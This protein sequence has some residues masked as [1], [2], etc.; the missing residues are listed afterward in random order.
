MKLKVEFLCKKR[1]KDL[2]FDCQEGHLYS[3]IYYTDRDFFDYEVNKHLIKLL[4][5]GYFKI[6]APW[7]YIPKHKE[8]PYDM[9]K[10]IEKLTE[11]CENYYKSIKQN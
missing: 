8:L 7:K 11:Y 5:K 1:I 10:K 2:V 9:Y 4:Q 6:I 3:I